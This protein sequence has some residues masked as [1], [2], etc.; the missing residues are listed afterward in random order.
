MRNAP[1]E[2]RP[3]AGSVGAE[4]HGVDLSASC[5]GDLGAI[6]QALLDHG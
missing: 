5:R 4:I 1:F 2:V 3:I 6:R